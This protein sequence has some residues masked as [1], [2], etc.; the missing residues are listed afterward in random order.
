MEFWIYM[1]VVTFLLPLTMLGFGL[2]L[3]KKPP[4]KNASFGYR[5]KASMKNETTWAFSQKFCGRLWIINGAC[6]LCLPFAMFAVINKDTETIGL[7][8]AVLTI[9]PIIP[10]IISI[11]LTEITLK[12]KFDKNGQLIKK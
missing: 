5:T 3:Y 6:M 1:T 12:R 7:F 11:I 8:G 10:M 2:L 9:M 4:N